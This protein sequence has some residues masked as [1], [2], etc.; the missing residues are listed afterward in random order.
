MAAATTTAPAHGAN[1]TRGLQI[2]E[3]GSCAVRASRP[4]RSI[5]LRSSA[6]IDAIRRAGALAADA[7]EAAGAACRIG[8]TTAAIDAAAE[9]AIRAGG[10]EPLFLGYRGSKPSADGSDRPAYP[11]STCVS[12]NEELVH[13]VPGA[14]VVRNGDLVAIDVGVRLDGWCADTAATIAVGDVAR[15]R[16]AMLSCA[17]SMLDHAIAAM[18]PGRRWS[19]IVGELESIAERGGYAIAADFVGHGIGRAL[20][21]APQVPCTLTRS[22]LEQHDFTLR[23][24]M[25]LAIEPMLVLEAPRRAGEDAHLVNPACRLG[26]DGWTVTLESGAPSCHVEH[27]V[28]VTRDGAEV[29]TRACRTS[30]RMRRAG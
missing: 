22:F 20:H 13:G 12:V 19:A 7:L 27:T 2:G 15:E 14:R 23:P 29:L 16:I 25:V 18:V 24:G 9:H 8:A 1:P 4:A 17:E 10:G 30:H 21:E 28:V 5:A 11:A 3:R 6:E 26:S